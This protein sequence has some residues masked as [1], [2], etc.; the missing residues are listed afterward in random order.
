MKAFR[1]GR[2]DTP[3]SNLEPPIRRPVVLR[4]HEDTPPTGLA[5][6]GSDQASMHKSCSADA[7][8]PT[9]QREAL[10]SSM[11]EQEVAAGLAS[12]PSLDWETQQDIAT[13]F[14]AL[15]ER[16]KV[17]GF[18]QCDYRAYGRELIRYGVLFSTFVL[19]L[20]AQ[21]YLTSA[22]FLGM[23]WVCFVLAITIYGTDP[24]DQQQIM[25]TAHDAGHRGI[26]SNFVVDTLIGITIADLCCGLSLGWWKSSHNVHHL[27]TNMP[28]R[29]NDKQPS[30]NQS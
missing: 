3:W 11:E 2:I 29:E 25:F 9:F 18:Y 17:E 23:F 10:I 1:I 15:H 8:Q 4:N 30:K 6:A 5:P 27:I 26:T 13:D 20:R 21:W 14:R 16:I 22:C 28:V 7:K 24:L 12:M 19:L